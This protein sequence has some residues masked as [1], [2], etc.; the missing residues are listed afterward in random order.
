MGWPDVLVLDEPTSAVDPEGHHAIRTLLLDERAR[1]VALLIT[2]HQ[3]ADAE[4][5]GDALTVLGTGQVVA[6]GTL[7]ELTGEPVVLFES[8]TNLEV[9]EL[10]RRL[11]GA[12]TRDAAGTYRCHVANS[13]LVVATITQFLAEQGAQLISLRTRASLEETYLA[14]MANSRSEEQS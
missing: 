5:L 11:G 6:A 7:A 8:S 1:G 3:L 4:L 13:A 14:L 9:S 12:V 10:A 2:T